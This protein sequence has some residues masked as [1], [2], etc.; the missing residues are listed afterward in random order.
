[1][2][3]SSPCVVRLPLS[4]P[5]CFLGFF[6]IYRDESNGKS[7]TPLFVVF[8]WLVLYLGFLLC[9]LSFFCFSRFFCFV[10]LLW[11]CPFFFQFVVFFS[12]PLCDL[13]FSGFY[14]QRTIRFFQPLIAGVM[15]AMAAAGIR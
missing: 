14:S 4:P 15:A 10:F 5:A 11:F 1:M 12:L 8:V 2:F 6:V 7:N 3:S 9:V 13:S